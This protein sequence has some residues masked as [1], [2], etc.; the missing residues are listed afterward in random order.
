MLIVASTVSRRSMTPRRVC[1]LT[2][3]SRSMAELIAGEEWPFPSIDIDARLETTALLVVDMQQFDVSRSHGV[4][5]TMFERA[6]ALATYYFDRVEQLVIPSIA[7]LLAAFRA[8][9]A[10]VIYVT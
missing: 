2:G 6:P 7:R 5:P 4:G 9:S 10:R 1:S 3:S 8:A